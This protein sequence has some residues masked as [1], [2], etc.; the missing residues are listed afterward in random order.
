MSNTP[1]IPLPKNWPATVKSAIL[2]VITLAQL[3]V[4]YTRSWSSNSPNE[5]IRFKARCEQLED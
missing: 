5:R 3:A 2:H 1:K 4:A